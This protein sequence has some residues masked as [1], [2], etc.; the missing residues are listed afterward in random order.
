M[1]GGIKNSYDCCYH[2]LYFYR[3][4]SLMNTAAP[5][6]EKPEGSWSFLSDTYPNGGRSQLCGQP[7]WQLWVLVYVGTIYKYMHLAA[8]DGLK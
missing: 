8:A 2:I 7:Y 1:D 3:A 5:W 6:T 4:G